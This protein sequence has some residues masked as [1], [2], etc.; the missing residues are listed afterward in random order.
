VEELAAKIDV[1]EQARKQADAAKVQAQEKAAEAR[2]K[3]TGAKDDMVR[4]ARETS[5]ET[6]RYV[7]GAALVAFLVGR[8]SRR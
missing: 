3:L 6:R 7:A 2:R 5:P 4:K 8:W 1:K